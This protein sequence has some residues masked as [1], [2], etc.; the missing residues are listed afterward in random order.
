MQ[1]GQP[2]PI[3]AER[4]P[5]AV[6]AGLIDILLVFLSAYVAH[7][8]RFD[9][10]AMPGSYAIVTVA[11]ALLGLVCQIILGT[12]SSWRGRQ[13]LQQLG[14]VYVGWLLTLAIL[15]GLAVFLKVSSDYSRVWLSITLIISVGLVTIFRSFVFL[16]LR[17]IRKSGKNLKSVITVETD[18]S[19]SELNAKLHELP[20]YGYQVVGNLT[21]AHDESWLQE[22]V[23]KVIATNAHE[24][25]LCLPLKQ[26]EAIKIILHALR[27][28]TV[29]VRYLPDMGDIPLLN[30]RISNIA[31]LYSLDISCSPMDGPAQFIKRTEDLIIGSIVALIILPICAVIAI[32]IK[33]SSRGPVIF[34]QYRTGMNGQ[35]FKVYKFRSMEVHSEKPGAVTQASLGDPRV[36]RLGAFLRKSSLDELPQFFNVLQGSMSIVGPRPHA[37]AHNEYYKN[38]VESY[39]KRHKVKPGITGWAQVNGYRGETSTLEK[40]Q[41]R[42]ASDLWYIDNWSLDLDLKIIFQTIYKGF[43]N[44]EP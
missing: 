12:Y 25:W 26:G 7:F 44:N 10:W 29:E 30:H 39:M 14:L 8:L 37:L 36:T 2:Q 4:Y 34:K 27:H 24:V 15:T 17:H 21:L 22:L 18:T 23:S 1:S 31:G 3:L 13:F 5:I 28:L 16:L 20:E 33:M 32:A 38:L 43:V 6:A 41:K 42:V 19:G 40:M 35:V 9:S 11:I